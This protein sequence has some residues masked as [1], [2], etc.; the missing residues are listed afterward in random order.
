MSALGTTTPTVTRTRWALFAAILL[1]A[2]NLRT[3]VTSV[4]PLLDVLEHDI[5]LSSG[6]AGVLTTLPVLSFAALGALTPRL[7]RRIGEPRALALG[8][9]LMTVG[10]FLRA[11]VASVWPFLLLTVVA[12]A[13]GA[14]GNVLLPV[15]VKRDFPNRI[16][17]VTAGYT[18]ALA[19]G[20]TLA[21]GFTIPLASLEGDVDWRR[22][23]GAWALPAAAGALCWV[24]LAA[25]SGKSAAH[26]GAARHYPVARSR[27]AWGLALFFG[28]QSMQ[29]Y[30]AFGWFALFFR[31]Q[32]GVSAARA[33]LLLAFLSALS[34]PTSMLIP[35]FAARRPNQRPVVVTLVACYAVAYVGML[36]APRA[37]AWLWVLLTGIGAGAFPLA[38]TLIG[39]RT[40]TAAA[41]TSLSAFTQSVGYVVAGGG[42]LVVGVLHGASHSWGLSFVLLFADLVVM[43]AAGWFVGVPRYVEED[44][45]T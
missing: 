9:V 17:T 33:G 38:L 41:T 11:T 30:I 27:T 7:A 1:V 6:L 15:L 20:T 3:A 18:T 2:V 45:G 25:R 10:L 40:R 28:A 36:V 21:A 26:D 37:G 5:G 19:V 35:P 29:A 16:G 32:A 4:G 13:G 24:W 23:L 39:L 22:G 43:L 8:M 14:M 31:E 44:L 42:P 12:L 34:I